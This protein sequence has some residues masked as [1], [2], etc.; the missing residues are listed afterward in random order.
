MFVIRS[1]SHPLFVSSALPSMRECAFH[2]LGLSLTSALQSDEQ[3]PPLAVSSSYAHALPLPSLT[4]SC[5][6]R[7]SPP[8][9]SSPA[10]SATHHGPFHRLGIWYD[11]V[12][13]FN[14]ETLFARKREPG[15][16]RSI[17]VQQPLPPDYYDNK[18]RLKK[19]KKFVSNQVITS[20]YTIITFL[21]R[22]LLEQFRRVANM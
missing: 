13:A 6:R 10:M 2:S 1:S 16:P 11:K 14:V 15:P 7:S 3:S 20:K 12:A 19:E 4:I 5:S 21:P 8:S 9:S 22:N 18:H 17:Y